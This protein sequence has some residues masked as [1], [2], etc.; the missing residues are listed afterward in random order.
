MLGCSASGKPTYT[1]LSLQTPL[2]AAFLPSHADK[3]KWERIVS[4]IIQ[5]LAIMSKIKR[6]HFLQF[7]GST[8][9]ALGLS[10]FDIQH[11]GN[12][13]GQVLA[14]STPRKLAFLVG[15]N[16]YTTAPLKGCV[17]D[18]ELQRQLLIHRFGFNSKDILLLTDERATRAGILEAFEGFLIDQ[19]KPGDV[20]VF[21]FSGHG[22]RVK[23]PDC[24]FPDCRNSTFVPSDSFLSGNSEVDDIMGHTLFLLMSALKTENFTAVLDSC[25]SGGGTRAPKL[26]GNLQVRSLNRGPEAKIKSSEQLYQER[27][28]SRLNLSPDEFKQTRKAGIAKGVAIASTRRDQLAADAPFGE[29][30]AGA[31]TYLM[32]QYLW[33]Q[34]SSTRFTAAIPAIASSTNRASFTSQ[35]PQ[36][37]VKPGSNNDRQPVYF[38]DATMPAAEA[39]I[40]KIQGNQVE[41]WLGGLD[42]RSLE[43]FGEGAVLSAIDSQGREQGQVRLESRSGLVGRGRFIDSTA[44][45]G[46]LLQERVRGIPSDLSLQIGL[47]PSLGR[48]TKAAKRALKAIRRIEPLP[49]RRQEVQYILGRMTDAYRQQL[50]SQNQALPALDSIGLFSPALELVPDSF[51]AAGET[52]TAAVTRLQSKFKSLLAAR[53]VKLALN[54]NASRLNIVASIKPASGS[55]FVASAFTVR[56]GESQGHPSAL[57]PNSIRNTR[58]SLG[59]K[60]QLEITN[61]ESRDLHLSVLAIDSAGDM[62]VLF[63]NQWAADDDVS[64]IRAGQTLQVPTPSDDFSLIVQEPKGTT[65]V[66]ILVSASPMST[67]LK[68]LRLVASHSSVSRGPL[69]PEEPTAVI[70]D[71]LFDLDAEQ[72]RGLSRDS[73]ATASNG[74][75]RSVDTSQLAALSITF[76]VV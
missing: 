29:F 10:Q 18:V 6:R 32:T 20:V 33:Q 38:I 57:P 3:L 16:S 28:L 76:E 55:Q 63:P 59:S 43:A 35:E 50:Q 69:A 64:R 58:L 2:P 23:D 7:A 48:D 36:L 73:T 46:S 17:T 44:R 21:H 14:K 49:L 52:V 11:C 25:H 15:I 34:M 8:L 5:N 66:L 24:D 45:V 60:V 70:D 47:D 75:I 41:V 4:S 74:K 61:K 31:F 12:R 65:E 53:V 51:G 72:Q 40:A 19:A 1:K 39:A 26:Q 22:S 71:L 37:E 67:A 27:W 13:Y 42:P 9:A 30:F 56:G 54:S 62:A 68:A